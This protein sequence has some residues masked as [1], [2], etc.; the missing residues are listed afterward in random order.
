M[1]LI[2]LSKITFFFLHWSPFHFYLENFVHLQVQIVEFDYWQL[3]TFDTLSQK[4]LAGLNTS[5][6]EQL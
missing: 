3:G 5:G 4:L 2:I 1:Q 6:G